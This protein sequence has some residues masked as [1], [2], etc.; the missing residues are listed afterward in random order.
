MSSNPREILGIARRAYQDKDYPT[1]LENYQ[2]FY[3]N[4]L[5]INQSFYGVRLSYCLDEWAELGK[6]FPDAAEALLR[7]KENALLEFSNTKSRIAFHEYSCICDYLECKEEVFQQFLAIQESDQDLAEKLFTVVYEYCAS[8]EMWETCRKYLGNG[9][10]QYEQS[11]QTFDHMVEFSEAKSG[12]IGESI[13][14]DA[15][16]AIKREA[17]WILNM[18]HFVNA[19]DEYESTISKIESDLKE[20]GR[21]NLYKEICEGTPNNQRQS[22]K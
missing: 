19:Q 8:Q 10:K 20:R 17:L 12:E 15:V 9:C 13:Y 18:L 22:T 16:K 6:V 5:Y 7:L 14:R 3:N 21:E 11:L 2:W 4:A 1:A